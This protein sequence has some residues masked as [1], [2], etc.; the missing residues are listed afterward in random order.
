MLT[1][2]GIPDSERRYTH[3]ARAARTRAEPTYVT[4][5]RGHGG[6][7][8]TVAMLALMLIG[9]TGDV[10]G[11]NGT[12]APA[13]AAL[14]SRALSSYVPRTT[15]RVTVRTADVKN[16]GTDAN[17]YITLYGTAGTSE[18]RQLD[19]ARN[20]FERNQLDAFN[21]EMSDIGDV[22]KIRIRHDSS[23]NKP[24]WL[25]DMIEVQKNGTGSISSFPCGQWL[26]DATIDFTADGRR[27]W[28]NPRQPPTASPAELRGAVVFDVNY[29]YQ[30]F[31]QT[32]IFTGTLVRADGTIGD[33]TFYKEVSQTIT[34]GRAQAIGF[35]VA[36]LKRGTWR[37]TAN[38]PGLLPPFTCPASVPGRVTLDVSVGRCY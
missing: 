24:G 7:R 36:N 2:A 26:A 1:E 6:S 21:L 3:S 27:C 13:S 14:P 8:S 32:V 33:A 19:D 15:Y 4:N 37:V 9:C 31:Q 16:A 22:N 12:Q 11:P 34:T 17:V 23:G 5:R 25:L 29:G 35:S 20:N 38:A 18:E 30:P 28:P 10:V